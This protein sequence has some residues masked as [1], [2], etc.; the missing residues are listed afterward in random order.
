M[1]RRLD[2][3]ANPDAAASLRVRSSVDHIS[4][5]GTVLVAHVRAPGTDDDVV[6]AIAV[7]VTRA[8]DNG[9]GPV[10]RACALEHEADAAIAAAAAQ[11]ARQG[12]H[13]REVSRRRRVASKDAEARPGI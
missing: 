1:R 2:T 7:H 9:T 13:A 4:R 6:D 5:A 12:K 3:P 11:Q 10:A 8:I